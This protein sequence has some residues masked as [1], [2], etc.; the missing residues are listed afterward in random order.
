MPSGESAGTF[1]Q[2]RKTQPEG[3]YIQENNGSFITGGS[4]LEPKEW[5][6]FIEVFVSG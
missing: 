3:V 5:E 2:Q 6:A 1:F 4:V